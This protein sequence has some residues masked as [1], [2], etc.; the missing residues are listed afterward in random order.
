[1]ILA[2]F[3]L[4]ILLLFLAMCCLNYFTAFRLDQ[5]KLKLNT[6]LPAAS[7]LI[8]ARNEAHNL[9]QL[10]PSLLNSNYKEFEILVLNDGSEDQTEKV[11]LGLLEKSHIPY[12]VIQGKKWNSDLGI[13]GKNY[14]C[15]QLAELAQ[16]EIFIFCDADVTVAADTVQKTLSFIQ[17]NPEASG[18]SGLPKIKSHGFYENLIFPWIMQIPLMISLPLAFAWRLPIASMQMANGQWLAIRKSA[19]DKS[20]GHR[21]LGTAVVEDMQL[22]RNLVNKSLGGLIPVLAA[23]DVSV[24]M[25][26]DWNSMVAGFSKNLILIYGGRPVYFLT[27]LMFV[28]LVFLVPLWFLGVSLVH[29]TLGLSA[30]FILR[31]LTALSFGSSLLNAVLQFFLHWP[32]L[33]V[34]NYFSILILNNYYNHVTDWKGR[35]TQQAGAR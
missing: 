18:M 5:V 29:V 9:A 14:A 32:S 35:K 2:N 25:Y 4:W 27:L 13:S 34:L 16:G 11:A 21:A 22:A 33:L 3:T 31:L 1:M 15:Q 7:V 30:L 19:Y 12:R 28:N 10:I 24:Q 8:P 6:H 26:F 17:Q 23:K 20:G